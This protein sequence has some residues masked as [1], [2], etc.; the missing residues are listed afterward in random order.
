MF[1]YRSK[2]RHSKI[3]KDMGYAF[4]EPYLKSY[5]GLK[6]SKDGERGYMMY[7]YPKV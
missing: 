7:P 1:I 3:L 5:K 2:K 4:Y 6:Q